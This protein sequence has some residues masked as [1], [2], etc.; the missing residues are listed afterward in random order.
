MENKMFVSKKWP[1]K[2]T[3]KMRVWPLKLAIKLDIVRWLA[4]IFSPVYIQEVDPLN[5]LHKYD[6][7]MLNSVKT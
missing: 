7:R 4:V 2:M 1:V 6:K 3:G 5:P